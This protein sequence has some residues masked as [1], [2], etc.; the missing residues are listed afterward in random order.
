LIGKSG[1]QRLARIDFQGHLKQLK[2]TNTLL[3]EEE[4]VDFLLKIICRF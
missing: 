1:Y 3:V 4:A 2:V